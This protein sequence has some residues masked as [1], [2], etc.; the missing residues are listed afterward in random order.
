M[1]KN[2]EKFAA[3]LKVAWKVSPKFFFTVA[4]GS[5]IGL[6]QVLVNVTLPKYLVDELTG[7]KSA[8]ALLL[9]GGAIVAANLLFA[10]INNLV[11][12]SMTVQSSY[13]NDK[14]QQALGEKLMNVAF[15]C[16]ENPYYLD[17]K[18]RASFVINN[19]GVVPSLVET[20]V[21][22]LKNVLTVAGLLALLVAFSP[23]LVVLLALT[24]AAML[25][26][27]A[28]FSGYMTR[29]FQE[30]I[31]VNRRYGYYFDF[32]FNDKVQK[33]V[34]LY[35]MCDMLVGSVKNANDTINTWYTE[36]WHKRGRMTG[37]YGMINNLQ[38]A[39]VYGY[40]GLR[41]F[42]QALGPKI[43][44]GSF[45][46]YVSAALS[47][48]SAV[49]E[50]GMQ[51]TRLAQNLSYL[52][53]FM[54]LMALPDESVRA[55]GPFPETVESIEFKDVSFRY[56]GADVLVLEGVSFKVE[57]GEKISVVGLNG[58]GKTTLVKLLCRLYEPASGSILINGRDI[59]EYDSD[60]YRKRIAAVFQDYK[61]FD[62]T[63]EENITCGEADSA[64][65]MELVGQVG[66]K[67]RVEGLKNG[68]RSLF[69]KAYDPE[70][71]ELS[72]GENQKVAIA[73]AL[74]REAS[75]IILDEPTSAL[76]PLAE[77]EIYEHFNSLVGDKTAF[78]ISHRMSSSVFCD[79]VLVL[80]NGAVRDFDTH[81]NLMKKIG[82][83][84]YKLFEAQA[85][86]YRVEAA[87][88]SCGGAAG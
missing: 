54:E 52:E 47:F 53:P 73:R 25:A 28:S 14:M 58:A 18:E 86:N 1:R 30:L 79:R 16:L 42:S 38:A 75:L 35:D 13:V 87:R 29:F 26:A 80:E 17:L 57:K 74:Y 81:Q 68:L 10:F 20:T 65:A 45:T 78:Y 69:G 60:S 7:S 36:F 31:P 4:F 77:A 2:V 19:Q 83:L 72:G 34:R 15:S 50:T 76:D 63:I 88:G 44:L 64:R 21:G 24:I 43:T 66:L 12:R 40:T 51:L 27:N 70:G 33:D 3:F 11:K 9:W 22:F 49:T 46:M 61:L 67:E 55:G 37:L 62:F 5:L 6:A 41:A 48:T 32:C 39:L 82:S 84:Y 56:P 71:I 85:E 59:F 8:E 23:V